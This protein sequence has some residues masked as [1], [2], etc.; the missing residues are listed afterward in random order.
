MERVCALSVSQHHQGKWSS[1][2]LKSQLQN[3]YLC[4]SL[5]CCNLQHP[6]GFYSWSDCPQCLLRLY[7]RMVDSLPQVQLYHIP[8]QHLLF[9]L[10]DFA[11]AE[12]WPAPHQLIWEMLRFQSF[13]P[14]YFPQSQMLPSQILPYLLYFLTLR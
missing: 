1:L 13:V 14:S 3:F 9:G 4:Q 6:R 10:I 11:I 8:F 2:L 7:F 12:S 5:E